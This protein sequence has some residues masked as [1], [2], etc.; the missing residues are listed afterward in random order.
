MRRTMSLSILLMIT[1]VV[2]ARQQVQKTD[3]D[4]TPREW[5]KIV[6]NSDDEFFRSDEAKRIAENVLVYQRLTGGWPK[7]IAIH[8]PLTSKEKATVV[9][10]KKK[11]N[12][13]TTDN[14]ATIL[15][16]TYL[17]LLYKQMPEA[18]Y[19]NAII[20]GLEFILS[21]QYANG[22]WPQFWPENR[23]YQVH[24]TYNDNAMGQILQL[25]R[26]FREGVA[27]F[28][29]IADDAMKARLSK[30]FDKGIGCV[31]KTQIVVDGEPTVWCQQYDHVTLKPAAARA[32]ELISY[33]SAESAL[34]TRLLMEIPNPD[35]QTKAA[36]N[37]AMKWFSKHKLTGIKVEHYTNADGKRDIRVIKDDNARP[38][39]ARYYDMKQVEPF[40]CDRD[41]VPKRTLAEVGYERR[42]GYGWYNSQPSRLYKHYEQWK[43]KYPATL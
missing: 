30:A 31:L 1:F 21:G 8:K 14:D 7:N 18:R 16:M 3:Y 13:S 17:A 39:W 11:R 26:D 27:P 20:N 12:D 29:G 28:S 32:Y 40:F 42:V 6:R 34:L 22:G 38:L 33:C 23:S 5:K 36:V 37:G 4:Y 15:E 35:E 43:K 24:I 2:S 9:A 19:K 25:L 41:G 10:D